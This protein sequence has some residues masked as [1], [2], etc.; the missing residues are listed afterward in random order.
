VY[1]GSAIPDLRGTYLYADYTSNEILA[2]RMEA[3]QVAQGQTAITGNLNPGQ[4]VE[5]IAS[6][7]QDNAGEMYIVSLD[8]S[9]YRIDPE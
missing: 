6:F 3:G 5:S 4:N 1:R 8:G 9:V 7:G 2:L